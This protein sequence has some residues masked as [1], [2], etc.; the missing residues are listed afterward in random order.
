MLIR[1]PFWRGFLVILCWLVWPITFLLGEFVVRLSLSTSRG[2]S[3]EGCT[4]A[5]SPIDI[6]VVVPPMIVTAL[7]WRWRHRR[8]S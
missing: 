7:W 5:L 8:V 3:I 1:F 4:F 2:C 6:L